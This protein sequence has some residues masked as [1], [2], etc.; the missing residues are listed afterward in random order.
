MVQG[1]GK[2]QEQVFSL[3]TRWINSTK[4]LRAPLAFTLVRLFGES[5]RIGIEH[6]PKSDKSF[7]V[8][9]WRLLEATPK[10]PALAIGQSSAWPSSEVTGSAFSVT[11]AQALNANWHAYL[12]AS[13]APD[14]ARWFLPAGLA[15]RLTP[16]FKARAMW[17]GNR[18]HPAISYQQSDWGLSFFLLDGRDPTLSLSVGF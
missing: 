18:L 7:L 6:M 16:A 14:Q 3:T 13:F 8:W 11:A 15:Y 2:I 12:S 5:F 17:D 4:T 1:S 10:T 9:N